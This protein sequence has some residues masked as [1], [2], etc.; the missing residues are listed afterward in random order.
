MLMK[1]PAGGSGPVTLET[2]IGLLE[3]TLGPLTGE[4]VNAVGDL[5]PDEARERLHAPAVP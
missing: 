4:M 2:A 3:L 1:P 5:S